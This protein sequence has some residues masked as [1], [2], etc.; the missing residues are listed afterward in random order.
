MPL[1]TVAASHRI[2][3]N[4]FATLEYIATFSL[5]PLMQR[6]LVTG[7]NKGIGLAI[8]T[9]LLDDYPNTHVLLGSRDASRGNAAVKALQEGKASRAGRVS[10]LLM[11]VADKQSLS[12]AAELV[13]QTYGPDPAPL[14][15]IINNAG[16][17]KDTL[18]ALKEVLDCNVH[19]PHNVCEAFLGLLDPV[20]G[21]CA[22]GCPAQHQC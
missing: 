19:G 1:L 2:D 11:D 22:A 20:A 10:M 21:R 17:Y 6:V 7:A 13:S 16:I 12:Q 3:S 14:H 8:A 18:A 9:R 4:V 5:S 15:G